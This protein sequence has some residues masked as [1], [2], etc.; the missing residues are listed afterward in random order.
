MEYEIIFPISTFGAY[1]MNQGIHSMCEMFSYC[2]F[3]GS[4]RGFQLAWTYCAK[5]FDINI[6]WLS[7]R[8]DYI[9]LAE[10]LHNRVFPHLILNTLLF[11]DPTEYGFN[12]NGKNEYSIGRKISHNHNICVCTKCKCTPINKN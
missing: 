3:N 12:F 5:L 10:F 8:T 2:F 6:T 11:A 1:H 7:T 4:I 9:I